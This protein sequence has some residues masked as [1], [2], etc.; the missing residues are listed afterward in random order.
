MCARRIRR[1]CLRSVDV[2]IALV[3]ALAA[4]LRI[5]VESSVTARGK[6]KG[7]WRVCC[8]ILDVA[9]NLTVNMAR[10]QL[11]VQ[12]TVFLRFGQPSTF[13]LIVLG[14]L[15]VFFWT[16]WAR[17]IHVSAK[18]IFHDARS[19]QH[20]SPGASPLSERP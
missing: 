6:R 4:Q 18:A 20:R 3:S 2:T 9:L 19:V 14:S 12:H 8:G 1:G 13:F 5:V 16:C 7:A 17:S 10:L 15:F 11:A